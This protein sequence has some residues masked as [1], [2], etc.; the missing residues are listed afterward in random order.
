MFVQILESWTIA[1]CMWIISGNDNSSAVQSCSVPFAGILSLIMQFPQRLTGPFL[2][3]LH[4]APIESLG[5]VDLL[6][7][8]SEFFEFFE[9]A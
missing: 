7:I 6:R 9:T 1:A 2:C 3:A 5:V 4:L 8:F